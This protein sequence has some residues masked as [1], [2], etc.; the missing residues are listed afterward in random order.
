MTRDSGHDGGGL[1]RFLYAFIGG[2]GAALADAMVGQVT[3][4][5]FRVPRSLLIGAS[6][7]L[8][9]W[10]AWTA[11]SRVAASRRRR[12]R[13]SGLYV[14]R[15]QM[16]E[17]HLLGEVSFAGVMWRVVAWQ[18]WMGGALSPDDTP[19]RME[20]ETPPR[21]PLCGTELSESQRFWGSWHWRCPRGDFAVRNHRDYR[22]VAHDVL[23]IAR[24]DFECSRP[25]ERA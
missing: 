18:S 7:G 20:V 4:Q 21:C 3:L 24:R 25:R 1:R 13:A 12:T 8:L 23:K 14:G 9:I 2:L 22:L 6:T 19:D 5:Q 17:R 11:V 10:V 15:S 16:M